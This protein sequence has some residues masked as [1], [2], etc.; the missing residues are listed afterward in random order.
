MLDLKDN[1]IDQWELLSPLVHCEVHF[2]VILSC[3]IKLNAKIYNGYMI[4]LQALRE[5]HLQL[6]CAVENN[7]CIGSYANPVCDAAAYR[8]TLQQVRT[9]RIC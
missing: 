3:P 8:N 2:T 7:E 5:L 9:L 6:D 1:A 4:A